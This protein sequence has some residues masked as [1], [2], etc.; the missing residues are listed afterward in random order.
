M[1][2][3]QHLVFIIITRKIDIKTMISSYYL[4]F[5][6]IM[7]KIDIKN[8]ISLL[9]EIL[10][11]FLVWLNMI[12]SFFLPCIY[13]YYTII[14]SLSNHSLSIMNFFEHYLRLKPHWTLLLY[15]RGVITDN[16]AH[17]FVNHDAS[18]TL[19]FSFDGKDTG[20][21]FWCDKMMLIFN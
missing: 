10:I 8:M 9:W 6:I 12:F 15:C 16:S 2:S 5:V 1:I 19:W 13:L 17:S 7:R 18:L 21:F 3:P 4:V 14:V 11:F 20:I